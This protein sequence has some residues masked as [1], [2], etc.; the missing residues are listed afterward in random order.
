MSNNVYEFYEP[1]RYMIRVKMLYD[2]AHPVSTR[3]TYRKL[4]KCTD[5]LNPIKILTGTSTLGIYGP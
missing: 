1:G 2:R 3:G 4:I 5:G